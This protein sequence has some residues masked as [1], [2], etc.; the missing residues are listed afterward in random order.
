MPTP[1]NTAPEFISLRYAAR[2]LYEKARTANKSLA[3]TAERSGSLNTGLTPASPDE[4]LNFMAMRIA[5]CIPVF[6]RK[7]TSTS[8]SEIEKS[9]I[10]QSSFRDGAKLLKHVVYPRATYWN[11]LAVNKQDF[12]TH[13]VKMLF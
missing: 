13:M 10:N 3:R 6:G 8:V 7:G 11:D 12:E 9:D 1:L 5:D 4:T 2:K